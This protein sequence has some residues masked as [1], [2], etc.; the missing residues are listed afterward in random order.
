MVAAAAHAA[1]METFQER[2]QVE[3]RRLRNERIELAAI[4]REERYRT[5]VRGKWRRGVSVGSGKN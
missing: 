2:E 5:K 4:L 3:A 1:A